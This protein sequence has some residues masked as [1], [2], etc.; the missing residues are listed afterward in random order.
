MKDD[1]QKKILKII[2]NKMSSRERKQNDL[3]LETGL[4]F[5]LL[6]LPVKEKGTF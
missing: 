2:R 5:W 6:T 4:S 3:N 1:R